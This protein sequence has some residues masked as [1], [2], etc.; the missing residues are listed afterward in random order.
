[1]NL[2]AEAQRNCFGRLTKAGSF[3]GGRRPAG[4]VRRSLS[5][6]GQAQ[7]A[8]KKELLFK[9]IFPQRFYNYEIRV[10]PSLAGNLKKLRAMSCELRVVTIHL[11]VFFIN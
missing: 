9:M 7:L 3:Y 10:I 2:T 4:I 11:E 1:M 8:A 6:D 5:E